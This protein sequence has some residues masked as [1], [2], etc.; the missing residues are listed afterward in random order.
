MRVGDEGSGELQH[1]RSKSGK[2]EWIL[3]TGI[4]VHL[5]FMS[6]ERDTVAG[7]PR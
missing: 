4:R 6:N 5:A 7:T 2:C 3:R 1:E